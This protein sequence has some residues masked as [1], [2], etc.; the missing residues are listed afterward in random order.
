[1]STIKE[2]LRLKYLGNLSNHN[3]EHLGVASKSAVTNYISH[4]NKSGLEI[5][6]ALKMQDEKLMRLLYPELKQ[7]HKQTTKPHPNWNY[8]H[9]ELKGIGVTMITYTLLLC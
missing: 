9:Q 3:V 1:M 2:V 7:Y 4:F 5:N 8:I 6:E